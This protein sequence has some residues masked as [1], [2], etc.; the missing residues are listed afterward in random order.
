MG[1]YNAAAWL[2][3]RDVHLAINTVLYT[4]LTLWEQQHVAHHHALRARKSPPVQA[5]DPD[6]VS[7]IAA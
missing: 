2:A 6:F 3:R 7:P 4:A 1:A 5:A